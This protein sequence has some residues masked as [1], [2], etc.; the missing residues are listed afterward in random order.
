MLLE[1]N[2]ITN[3]YFYCIHN[4]DCISPS[5]WRWFYEF[6]NKINHSPTFCAFEPPTDSQIPTL[7]KELADDTWDSV[8]DWENK[9]NQ[10]TG[11]YPLWTMTLIQIPLSQ[12]KDYDYTKCDIVINY[13]AKP[14]TTNTGFVA[15]GMTIPNLIW[16]N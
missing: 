16:K 9:L 4:W 12:Q 11:K 5:I 6:P 7:S 2:S 1:N 10:G 13:L 15:T 3:N 14:N 8:M